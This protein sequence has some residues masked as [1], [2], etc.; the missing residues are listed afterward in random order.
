MNLALYQS[1]VN[2]RNAKKEE[3]R[4]AMETNDEVAVRRLIVEIQTIDDFIEEME[5]E[6]C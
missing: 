1:L 4:Y 5:E 3:L 2:K 6:E